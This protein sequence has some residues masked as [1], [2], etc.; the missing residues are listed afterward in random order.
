M[1]MNN[2]IL[3]GAS[4][5]VGA[6]IGS[7]IAWFAAKKRYEKMHQEQMNAVWADVQGKKKTEKELASDEIITPTAAEKP[8][9]F[10]YVAKI[11]QEGYEHPNDLPK[12]NDNIYEI[13]PMDLDEE[14][15]KRIDLT[16]YADG[17]LADDLDYPVRDLADTVGEN[18]A[19]LF[20]GRDEIFVR[21]EKHNIDY[22]IVISELTYGKMLDRQ[23][24]TQQR[25]DYANAMDEYYDEDEEEED[26]D[27]E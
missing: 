15:Y 23:P 20:K 6:A 24:E 7:V 2:Y 8:D 11:Q 25:L 22:D 3:A 19:A 21:N 4:F 14:L 27:S 5:L 1:S 16:Y 26:D 17:I 9:I 18:F 12:T 13:T 10:E